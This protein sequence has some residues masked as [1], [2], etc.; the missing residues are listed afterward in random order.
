MSDDVKNKFLED[1]K[2]LTDKELFDGMKTEKSR[3]T[4]ALD[5]H[6]KI[7]FIVI[8]MLKTKMLSL[9]L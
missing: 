4:S 8:G 3:I 7:S 2:N 6:R 9:Q 1:T 5:G